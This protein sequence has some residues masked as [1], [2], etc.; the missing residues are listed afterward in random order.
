MFS[1]KQRVVVLVGL[2]G[3]GKSTWL[4]N[5]G[6]GALSSDAMRKLLRDDEADQTIH[7]EVFALLRHLLRLRLRL[8]AA[9]TYIDSTN[10]TRRERRIWVKIAHDSGADCEAVFFDLPLAVCL[11]RNEKRTRV[12]PAEAMEL[13]AGRLV[14][15]EPAEGFAA[16]RVVS[17]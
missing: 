4:A 6:G 13:M 10:L 17:S 7:G 8:G 11:A 12:V 14:R 2:P 5:Q 15:P 9:T 16:I 3:S 1:S